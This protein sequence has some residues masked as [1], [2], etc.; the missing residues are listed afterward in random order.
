[1]KITKLS[2]L[3]AFITAFAFVDS[4]G[5]Q[6][7]KKDL[8]QVRKASAKFEEVVKKGGIDEIAKIYA[9]DALLMPANAKIIKGRQAIKE[10]FWK[11]ENFV[12]FEFIN[13]ESI[14]LTVSGTIAYEIA[15]CAI[16]YQHEGDQEPNTSP[17]AKILRIWKKQA[18][19][20]WKLHVEMWNENQ[21]PSE[22]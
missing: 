18:D 16:K 12:Y 8:E 7:E 2:L 9:E 1:M 4:V 22:T 20:S 11:R 3:F 10:D 14:E 19:G 5:A 13:K 17:P 6:S 15:N 21:P